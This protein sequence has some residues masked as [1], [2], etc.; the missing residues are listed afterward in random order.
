MPIG[1]TPY[2]HILPGK[3]PAGSKTQLGL[4]PGDIIKTQLLTLTV[5]FRLK[6]GGV[7]WSNGHGPCRSCGQK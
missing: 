5:V 4:Q 2:M 1:L 3:T 6:P 7:L